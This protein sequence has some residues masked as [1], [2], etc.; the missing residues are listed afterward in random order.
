MATS[1]NGAVNKIQ[2]DNYTATTTA[3]EKTPT[4]PF[5]FLLIRNTDSTNS[6][7]VSFDGD[8][9]YFTIPPGS[10]LSLE[11]NRMKSYHVKSSASTIAVQ[12]LYGSETIA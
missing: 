10:T 5:N 4:N 11:V 3:A 7:L 1:I 2:H 6:V 9:T 8:V 12:C